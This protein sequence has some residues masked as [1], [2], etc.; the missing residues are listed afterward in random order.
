MVAGANPLMP[1]IWQLALPALSVVFLLALIGI[2]VVVIRGAILNASRG[3]EPVGGRQA[4]H[5][6]MPLQTRDERLADL[7]ELHRKTLLTDAQYDLAVQ[8]TLR[9]CPVRHPGA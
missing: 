3:K 6:P 9:D 2:V 1:S 7:K 8:D 5:S 4:T